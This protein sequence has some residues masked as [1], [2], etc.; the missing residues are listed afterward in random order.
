MPA[1]DPTRFAW[2]DTPDPRRMAYS[3]TMPDSELDAEAMLS[4]TLYESTYATMAP[5][6]KAQPVRGDLRA[7]IWTS[8]VKTG[9]NLRTFYFVPPFTA[10]SRNT[11]F[12]TYQTTEAFTWPAVLDSVKFGF[13]TS[14]MQNSQRSGAVVEVPTIIAKVRAR[15]E[16]NEDALFTV[17]QFLSDQPWPASDL[18]HSKPVPTGVYWQ[19]QGQNAG[20]WPSCLHRAVRAQI[21]D[22]AELFTPILNAGTVNDGV[23]ALSID[24]D[25]TIPA[26]N[27]TDWTDHIVRDVVQPHPLGLYYRE[28][29]EVH[30]PIAVNGVRSIFT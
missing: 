22:Y 26:T 13:D 25:E 17:R 18:R 21:D 3:I 12:K 7:Y 24:D 19:F 30:S 1:G 27:F 20:S 9:P 5:I 16:F 23:D 8:S 14:I 2:E 15:D 10:A 28:Q 4:F 11:P 29:W 6:V